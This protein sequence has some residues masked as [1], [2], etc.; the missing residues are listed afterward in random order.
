MVWAVIGLVMGCFSLSRI[1]L[2]IL[3]ALGR[4]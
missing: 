2:L 3:S 4:R 1:V